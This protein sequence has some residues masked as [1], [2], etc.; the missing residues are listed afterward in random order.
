ML[1]MIPKN[2][3]S[4]GTSVFYVTSK[5]PVGH[6]SPSS[7]TK[8]RHVSAQDGL[9]ADGDS[10]KRVVVVTAATHARPG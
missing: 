6:C 4:S 2:L 3:L 9:W 7:K 10:A 1:M 8:R 5:T